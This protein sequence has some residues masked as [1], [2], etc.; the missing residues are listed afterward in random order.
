LVALGLAYVALSRWISSPLLD[1]FTPPQPYRWVSPPPEFTMHNEQPSS[2]EIVIPFSGDRSDPA[3]AFTE[4]G[5]VTISF[6]PGTFKSLPGQSGVRVRITPV[7]PQPPAP[8]GLVADGNA[9]LIEATYV[10]SGQP[11]LPQA[12]VLLDMRYPGHKPDGIF[13]ID[14]ADWNPIGGI[15]QDLLLTVDA[16]SLQLGVF[17]AAHRAASNPPAIPAWRQLVVPVLV[18][19]AALG[20]VFWIAGVRVRVGRRR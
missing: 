11:A 10:P 9:Y 5:Q 16:R 8:S 1:A 18:G 15:A 13:R 20:L 4:D 6:N 14:G 7:R 2:G 19:V 12:P 17:S 3:S